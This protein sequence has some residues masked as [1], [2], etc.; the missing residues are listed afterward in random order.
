PS[1]ADRASNPRPP[2]A[3][4]RK[5]RRDWGI[6][7]WGASMAASS[8][9]VERLVAVHH[10]VA[11]VGDGTEPGVLRLAVGRAEAVCLPAHEVEA[12]AHFFRRSRPRPGRAVGR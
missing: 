6:S 10:G 9:D 5:S 3:R 4:A 2:P 11:E 1:S 8:V 7:W 12:Q